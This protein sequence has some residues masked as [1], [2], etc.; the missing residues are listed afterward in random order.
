MTAPTGTPRTAVTGSAGSARTPRRD[1]RAGLQLTVSLALV[2]VI[3]AAAVLAPWVAPYGPLDGDPSRKYLPVGADGHLLGTDEL[4]RDLLSRVIYGARTSLLLSVASVA[5]ATVVGTV[6]GLL[7]AFTGPRTSAVIMRATDV[8]FA[9]PVI[10]VAIA[11]AALLGTSKSVVVI[12]VVIA[13]TP[14]VTRIVFSE[15][16]TQR[17]LEYVEAARSLGAGRVDI[18]FREVFPNISAPVLVYAT[19]LVGTMIVFSASLSAVG[20]GVQPPEADWG[21]MIASGAK[22]VISGNMHVAVVPGLA[23][24]VASLAFTWLGDALNDRFHT[25]TRGEA[26]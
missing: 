3:V 1:A 6:V 5:G 7:A 19:G 26:R 8:A 14:Y 11:L 17:E 10:L 9:F 20:I 21:Q 12:A 16:K 2:T 13:V 22:V 15:A 23:V 18:I 24:L 25:R 4:G